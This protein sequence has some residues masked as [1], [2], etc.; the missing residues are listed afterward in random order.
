MGRDPSTSLEKIAISDFDGQTG[1]KIWEYDSTGNIP[2]RF[3]VGPDSR[4]YFTERTLVN[5]NPFSAYFGRS[6]VSLDGNTGQVTLTA[7]VGTISTQTLVNI[8]GGASLPAGT[9]NWAR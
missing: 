1:T 9:V 5:V 6:L 8:L 7:T 2:G 4:I 3:A